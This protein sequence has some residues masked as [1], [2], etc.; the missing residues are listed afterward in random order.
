MTW[1]GLRGGIS[2]APALSLPESMPRDLIVG[3][4]YVV[5]IFSII[6]QGLSI[7]PLVKKPGLSTGAASDDKSNADEGAKMSH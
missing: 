4:T 6:V 2:V 5:V 7:G 3:V 1:G